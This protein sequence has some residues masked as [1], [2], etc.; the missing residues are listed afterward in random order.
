MDRTIMQNLP[1]TSS[2]IGLELKIRPTWQT[3]EL[4]EVDIS[5]VTASSMAGAPGDGSITRHDS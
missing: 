4:I 2:T 3:P 1:D 5:E